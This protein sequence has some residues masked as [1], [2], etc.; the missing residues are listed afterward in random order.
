[1]GSIS[2]WLAVNEN[3]FPLSPV[4]EYFENAQ[5]GRI[6]LYRR[7]TGNNLRCFCDRNS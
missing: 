4:G 2:E 7:Q 1:M 6:C 5:M 3:E